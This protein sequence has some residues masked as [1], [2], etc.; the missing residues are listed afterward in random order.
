MPQR[1]FIC[2]R[3][4]RG[5]HATLKGIEQA[6]AEGWTKAPG[7]KVCPKCRTNRKPDRLYWT[8]RD[9]AEA[10]NQENPDMVN[11]HDHRDQ[12]NSWRGKKIG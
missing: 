6:H 4:R 3:C 8:K 9:I 12:I 5:L 7:P 2:C 1:F 10:C 11:V